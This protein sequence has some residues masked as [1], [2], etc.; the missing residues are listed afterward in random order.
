MDCYF[1]YSDNKKKLSD[2]KTDCYFLIL[3]Q[4]EYH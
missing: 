2:K 4:G 3:S 1:P